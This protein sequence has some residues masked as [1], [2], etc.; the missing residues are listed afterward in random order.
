MSQKPVVV[1]GAGMAGL[2]CALDLAGAGVPCTVLEAS[3]GPGGRV[4]TDKVDG[5]LLDR[6]FQVL[7]TAY[8]EVKARLDLSALKLSRFFPGAL[9]RLD[10][11]FHKIGDPLRRPEAALSTLMAP[12]GSWDDKLAVGRLKR[13][14]REGSLEE[15]WSRPETS[16]REALRRHGFSDRIVDTFFRPFLA[17]IFLERELTTSSRFF[18]FVFRMFAEG[19]AALPARGM[20]AVAEQLAAR[21]PAGVLRLGTHVEAL[22][23]SGV[24]LAGGETLAAAAVV[25]AADLPEASRLLPEL[26]PPGRRGTACLYFAATEAPLKKPILVLDGEGSGPVNN[27]CVPSAVAPSYAPAGQSLVSVST[28]GIPEQ[29]DAALEKAVRAQLTGWFGAAVA[30][31]RHLKTY[32]IP[33]ALPARTSL[34]PAALPVCPRPGLFVCGDHRETPSLQGAMASGRRAA[35]AV[36]EGGSLKLQQ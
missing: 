21:L 3:D 20:G 19:H 35:A 4:R 32:R 34:D 6:G 24:R 16:T 33:F 27:L 28:V 25:V 8:P 36:L 22:A 18:E 14:V 31:W 23:E 26:T 17:G 1:I 9:V 10:G 13:H 29:D 12:V 30:S 7:Q 15:L 11:R 2:C 5:F